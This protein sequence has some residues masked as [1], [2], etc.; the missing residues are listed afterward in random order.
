MSDAT[1]VPRD[2]AIALSLKPGVMIQR[3]TV[4]PE[5]DPNYLGKPM[6]PY[7]VTTAVFEGQTYEVDKQWDLLRLI[8]DLINC[9]TT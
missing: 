7:V 6:G 1:R 2:I 4:V 5:V 3:E 8:I 9:E